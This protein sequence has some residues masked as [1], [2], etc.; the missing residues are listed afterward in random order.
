MPTAKKVVTPAPTAP[1]P[2]APA[3]PPDTVERARQG[4][5]VLERQGRP[6][7]L[8]TVLDGDGRILTAL[9]P[10]T[11]GNFVSARYH[12]GSVVPLKLQ[13]SDRGWDLALL[14]PTPTG[15]Q[16]PKKAGVRA[17]KQPSFVGLQTFALG[18]GPNTVASA[19]ASLKLTAGLQGGDS[20]TLSEAYE[21][22][23]KPAY[24]GA[25][26]VNAAGEV[27]AV[28]ARACPPGSAAGCAPAPY[29]A[30]VSALKRFLQTVPA[31]AAWLGIEAVGDEVKG[32]RGVRVSAV[33][34]DSPA[35]VAGLRPGKD[36]ALAD[37]IVAVDGTPV[38]SL[39]ELNDAVRSHA[40]GDSIELLLFGM[41]RYRHV[42]VRPRPAPE[43]VKPPYA[44]PKPTKPRTP[45]PYR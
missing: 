35:A 29:A 23:T 14:V 7:S 45:N 2:A 43:L 28:V 6:L 24:V 3:A 31:Q 11:N 37:L 16:T 22:G 1:P 8:G 25:P 5:V 40:L 41:G 32:V 4:V 39:V 38:A 9:S 19:P 42:S 13:H 21:L 12:D 20:T 15:Q 36:A 44:A 30:P 10:L 33:V 18:P 34:P 26:I 27:V 17:A